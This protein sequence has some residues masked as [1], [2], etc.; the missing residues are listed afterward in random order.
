[1]AAKGI[2]DKTNTMTKCLCQDA[3]ML[4]FLLN[5]VTMTSRAKDPFSLSY[6]TGTV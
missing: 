5:T 3:N 6:K 2:K 1:M 4:Q